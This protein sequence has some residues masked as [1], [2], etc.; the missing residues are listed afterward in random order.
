MK[1]QNQQ[2]SKR[3]SPKTSKHV[4]KGYKK[5]ASISKHASVIG[6]LGGRPRGS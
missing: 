3:S 4:D 5:P 1:K 2:A 6:K